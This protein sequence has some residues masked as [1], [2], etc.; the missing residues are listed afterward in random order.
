MVRNLCNDGFF[1]QDSESQETQ[2]ATTTSPQ[3][4]LTEDGD[5]PED[6]DW[7]LDIT[8]DEHQPEDSYLILKDI[9]WEQALQYDGLGI[10]EMLCNSGIYHQRF[11][12]HFLVGISFR[13]QVK[14]D[15]TIMATGRLHPA[16]EH[17][18]D[19]YTHESE[20]IL[21]ADITLLPRSP[22]TAQALREYIA[23]H[24]ADDHQADVPDGK[25]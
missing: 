21:T 16:E 13:F 10:S 19:Y 25:S 12:G 1:Q 14:E 15:G 20:T 8:V 23:S 18:G 2:G 9:E 5:L 3:S 11:G 4:L 17:H 22:R 6:L 24:Q 7:T